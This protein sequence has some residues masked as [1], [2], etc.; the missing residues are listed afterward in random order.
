MNLNGSLNHTY[1]VKTLLSSMGAIFT[2]ILPKQR[3]GFHLVFKDRVH[4]ITNNIFGVQPGIHSFYSRSFLLARGTLTSSL[5]CRP[6]AAARGIPTVPPPLLP[7]SSPLP[8][9]L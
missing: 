5:P 4:A 6:H 2:F 9:R 1:E 8:R 3:V 7:L